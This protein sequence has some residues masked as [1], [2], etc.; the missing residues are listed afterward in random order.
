MMAAVIQ[1]QDLENAIE[2]LEQINVRVVRMPSAGEFLERHNA[3]I[4]IGIPQGKEELVIKT[5]QNCLQQRIETL[6]NQS[7]SELPSE[8][9]IIGAT[10]FSFEI[11]RYEEI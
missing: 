11:E 8:E 6:P 3:T 5:L 2:A 1:E 4:L 10:L 7:F 9:I